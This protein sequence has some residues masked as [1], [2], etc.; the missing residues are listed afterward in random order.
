[1]SE[2]AHLSQSELPKENVRRQRKV[3]FVIMIVIFEIPPFS[4]PAQ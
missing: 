1:M 4:P 3:K 2:V